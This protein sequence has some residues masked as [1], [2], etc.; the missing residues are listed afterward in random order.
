MDE[1]LVNFLCLTRLVFTIYFLQLFFII[2]HCSSHLKGLTDWPTHVTLKTLVFIRYHYFYLIHIRIRSNY[3]TFPVKFNTCRRL[4]FAAPKLAWVVG[5]ALKFDS[6]GKVLSLD[7][8]MDANFKYFFGHIW[9]REGD[10]EICEW[11]GYSRRL[12]GRTTVG[13]YCTVSFL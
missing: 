6:I 7:D 12:Y 3:Y 4:W 13:V 5:K 2:I 11:N 9:R 10:D 8:I 1:P